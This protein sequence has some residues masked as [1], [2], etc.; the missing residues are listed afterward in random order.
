MSRP[1][2]QAMS[3]GSV[4]PAPPPQASPGSRQHA[5]RHAAGIQPESGRRRVLAAMA[6]GAALAVLAGCKSEPKFQGTDI[7]GSHLGRD[8]AMVDGAGR[9]RTLADYKGK[10]LVVFFGYTHCPD[11]CP[12]VM[13]EL[14]QAMKLLKDDAK[15]TQV[16]M[17]TVDPQ[18]DTGAVMNAY[19]KA[20]DPHFVGLTGTA[21]QLHK[22]AQSFKA[23]YAKAPGP[24]PEEYAMNHSS[25]FYLLDQQGE[26]RV[27]LNGDAPAMTIAGDI[28]QL[29]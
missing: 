15:K 19:V 2:L 13:S 12:T 16:I 20:F 10:V 25:S 11:V 3:V 4:E 6:A 29:L 14:A 21:E 17:I 8:M 24:T 5:A 7:T 9:L 27:L 1:Q 23:Y 22:T 18:R 28:R 26:A